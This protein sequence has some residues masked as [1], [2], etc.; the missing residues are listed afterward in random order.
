MEISV[1][2]TLS[3]KVA[4]KHPEYGFF[5]R[6]DGAVFRRIRNTHAY[7]WTYGSLM[8][9]GYMCVSVR[10]NEKN[11]PKTIHR[12]VADCFLPN[13]EFKKTV[14]HINRIRTD[15]RITN[16]RWADM[17]EQGM[18]SIR[19]YKAV[20]RWGFS[21]Y[22]DRKKYYA[23]AT[24][25][26][27]A[28]KRSKG[29]KLYS[30]PDGKLRWVR[31]YTT[32]HPLPNSFYPFHIVVN[33]EQVCILRKERKHEYDKQY[34]ALNHE[35]IKQRKKEYYQAH[36]EEILAKDKARRKTN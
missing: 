23:V 34:R 21:P 30:C 20:E 18:N 2:S 14:D 22:D 1:C 7:R 33:P 28:E 29:F 35:Y 12:M 9:N 13:P 27:N 10:I 36:K 25:T 16:L 11:I 3:G 8:A 24:R 6:E 31:S 19:H 15:N 32:E 26:R 17:H 5:I 4:L